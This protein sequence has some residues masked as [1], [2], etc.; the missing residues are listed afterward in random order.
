MASDTQ[1]A[2]MKHGE[3]E[4]VQEGEIVQTLS[5]DVV[6]G[7][8]AAVVVAEAPQPGGED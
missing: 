6:I 7:V 1:A 2:P 8:P 4:G 5:G 3:A